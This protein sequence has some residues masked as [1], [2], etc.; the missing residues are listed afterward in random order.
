VFYAGL[1]ISAGFITICSGLPRMRQKVLKSM[2]GYGNECGFLDQD[3]SIKQTWK[4]PVTP[5]VDNSVLF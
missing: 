3:E 2:S 5:I 1:F 4:A